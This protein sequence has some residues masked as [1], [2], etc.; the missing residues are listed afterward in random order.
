MTALGDIHPAMP[1]QNLSVTMPDWPAVSGEG[2]KQALGRHDGQHQVSRDTRNSR[3]IRRA[4]V[5]PESTPLD[6]PSEGVTV[7]YEASA[8]M[9]PIIRVG[10]QLAVAW[11]PR[12]RPRHGAVVAYFD[13]R[14]VVAHRLIA[15]TR[16]GLVLKGDAIRD[17]DPFVDPP[18]YCGEVVAVGRPDGRTL[19]LTS[20]HW[21]V[22]GW[23]LATATRLP[24]RARLRWIVTRAL[25]HIAAR[26]LR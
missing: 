20:R 22:V 6:R 11:R 25:C 26:C 9:S 19:E 8:S 12:S 2:G 17:A 15:W 21:R 10:D 3:M 4:P 5:S 13:G 24:A 23:A 1:G 14:R 18:R 16:T 7:L